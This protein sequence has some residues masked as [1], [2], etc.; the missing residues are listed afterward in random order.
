MRKSERHFLM[1]AAG[2]G[3][4]VL[5]GFAMIV[6]T[7]L[8]A[9]PAEPLVNYSLF[10]LE[11][12]PG[13]RVVFDGGSSARYAIDAPDIEKH[14]GYPTIVIADHAGVPIEAKLTRIRRH[15]QK[16]DTFILPLEWPYYVRDFTEPVL[17]RHGFWYFRHY[18]DAMPT[19]ARVWF[20]L[21][22]TRPQDAAFELGLRLARQHP[23]HGERLSDFRRRF[24]SNPYG[25]YQDRPEQDFA[26]LQGFTCGPYIFLRRSQTI[27]GLGRIAEDIA[28]IAREKEIKI[29]IAW[30]AVAGAD[31]YSDRA[32]VDRMAGDVRAAFDKVGIPVIGTPHRS[33]FPDERY[34]YDTFYH[35]TA[36]GAAIHTRRL[37]EDIDAAGLLMPSIEPQK[38]TMDY[39]RAA[40]DK[41]AAR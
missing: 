22:N 1:T 38:P 18:L 34:R 5:S 6:A 11:S 13:P 29:L 24:A 25:A 4:V 37:I 3:L 20:A 31:C 14:Y 21:S 41:A 16:G 15:A 10:L 8:F 33:W 19:M 7:L 39:V 12:V 2:A 36:E 27:P 30:P 32:T 26:G 35:L 23:S 9:F 40:L 17:A 28:S